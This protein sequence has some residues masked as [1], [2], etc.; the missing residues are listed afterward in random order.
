M[1][2]VAKRRWEK[3]DGS[4]GEA[5]LC[6]Y[7]DATGAR[8][9]RTFK[10]KKEA[11]RF[12]QSV[13]IE[14]REGIHGTAAK[15]YTV[16]S[17]A[18]DYLRAIDTM[19]KEGRLAL[20]TLRKEN[21]YFDRHI[22][23]QLGGRP[24]RDLSTDDVDRWLI[25]LKCGRLRGSGIKGDGKLTPSTI[26]QLSAALGRAVDFAQRRKLVGKNVVREVSKWREHRPG[27]NEPIR[28]FSIDE[29]R[30]LLAW[31]A[32]Q[33]HGLTAK[34]LS[35]ARP[36][37]TRRSEAMVRS[38]AYLAAFCGLR[39]GEA[40]GLT[41]SHVDFEAN[42]IRVRH[43]LDV[44][45][46]LK[47][48]KTRAGVRDVPMPG[49]LADEL[50]AWKAYDEKDPRGLLFRTQGGGQLTNAGFHRGYW[51]KALVGAGL[52]PDERNRRFHFHALRHF[53]ASMYIAGGVP[54]PDVA[55]LMGHSSFDMTLQVY[56]HPVIAGN[57]RHAAV[58]A[59]A[60]ALRENIAS[61]AT[62]LTHA[63]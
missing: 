2:S 60:H 20:S 59:M 14:L 46:N 52:G 27:K 19:H 22:V 34:G 41:W 44:A 58:E 33:D 4:F 45:D 32:P 26:K 9:G 25:A 49:I 13:E 39:L 3:P 18:D 21:F 23:P 55:Q 15:G 50:R 56:A 24:L 6:R 1:A 47:A 42:M 11:D 7:V 16:A 29:A 40:L 57:K 48:P 61:D 53:C 43:S 35:R 38:M 12:R 37:W 5:W 62:L 51:Q 36:G 31:I 28:T 8:R 63:A 30:Q 54:L 17:L 10:A